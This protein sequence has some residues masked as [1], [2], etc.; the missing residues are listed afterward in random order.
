MFYSDILNT[1]KFSA[2]EIINKLEY[3]E[4]VIFCFKFSFNKDKAYSELESLINFYILKYINIINVL[5][6]D[7]ENDSFLYLLF[8]P[9]FTY[10]LCVIYSKYLYC[11][12]LRNHRSN[13]LKKPNIKLENDRFFKTSKDFFDNIFLNENLHKWIASFFIDEKNSNEEFRMLNSSY[14]NIL[15]PKKIFFNCLRK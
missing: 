3:D 6:P 1:Q 14:E 15:M 8:R 2:L 7:V 5:Y 10:S 4:D 11:L 12:Y 13:I 9:F